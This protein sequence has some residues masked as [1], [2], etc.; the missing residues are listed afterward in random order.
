MILRSPRRGLPSE[1]GSTKWSTASFK[2]TALK[3][4][5][6]RD[7]AEKVKSDLADI[8]KIAARY[9]DHGSDLGRARLG[10][11]EKLEALKVAA[12]DE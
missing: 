3:Q 5:E 2:E 7:E 1:A 4:K 8:V 6:A 11:E 9:S 12:V 10:L